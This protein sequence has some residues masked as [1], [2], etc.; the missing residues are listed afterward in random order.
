MSVSS[1]MPC[2]NFVFDWLVQIVCIHQLRF[3][4]CACVFAHIGDI[5]E[6][7]STQLSTLLAWGRWGR[8]ERRRKR[9]RRDL[10]DV[11]VH[12]P[13]QT[14]NSSHRGLCQKKNQRT[15]RELGQSCE[16][17][18]VRLKFCDYIFGF[19]DGPP[20]FCTDRRWMPA[21]P[22]VCFFFQFSGKPR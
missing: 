3:P 12:K 6:Q 9:R 20:A 1:L 13:V 4:T 2:Q 11:C 15:N 14:R 16:E 10:V 7:L 19:F 8:V 22:F 18:K 5:S 21:N 17:P